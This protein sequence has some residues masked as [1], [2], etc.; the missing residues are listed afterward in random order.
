MKKEIKFTEPNGDD[1]YPDKHKDWLTKI[2]I[3]VFV[4][5]VIVFVGVFVF[6]NF[7]NEFKNE[8]IKEIQKNE[9]DFSGVDV[10]QEKQEE[11]KR[12][13]KIELIMEDKEYGVGEE[14][15]V[16]AII[17]TMG[18]NIVV[19]SLE[20]NYDT[21]YL[22]LV[23]VENKNS[24]L[25]MS[26]ME[27]QKEGGVNIVRG[28]PGDA[29]YLDED[30]GFT[31]RGFLGEFVFKVLQKGETKIEIGKENTSI[32]LDDGKATEMKVIYQNLNL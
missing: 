7:R 4:V 27:S 9:N 25:K 18:A 10:E 28:N 22:E 21:G 19:A 17:D 31:G 8:P 6:I 11:E 2:V 1:I 15:K 5:I 16:Q 32:M 26:V 12:E 24:V 29:D 3:I 13:G 23:K 20:L 14:I 30:D